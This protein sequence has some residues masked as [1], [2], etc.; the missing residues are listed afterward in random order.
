MDTNYFTKWLI[1]ASFMTKVI[2]DTGTLVLIKRTVAYQEPIITTL[3]IF[4]LLT[5]SQ[6]MVSQTFTKRTIWVFFLHF[7]KSASEYS[8]Q[9][10]ESWLFN[11]SSCS[12][13]NEHFLKAFNTQGDGAGRRCMLLKWEEG[14]EKRKMETA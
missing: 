12:L 8:P 14:W 4:K 5:Q 10:Q 6:N 2:R 1:L 7:K 13:K 11:L 9:I 3:W